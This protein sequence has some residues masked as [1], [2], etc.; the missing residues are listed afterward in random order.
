M[1]RLMSCGLVAAALS[2]LLSM[3]AAAATLA[4]QR[5][6]FGI[7][8]YDP[9]PVQETQTTPVPVPYAWIDDYPALLA[10]HSG[11]YEAAANASAANGRAV[12]TCYM[13][14]L[15]PLNNDATND[16][17]I[18]S[19]PMNADG[20]PDL[21]NILFYPPQTQW[22]VQGASP[23]LKGAASLDAKTWPTVTDENKSLFR[24]FKVEVELP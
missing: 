1:S 8:T 12:W 20:T 18:T 24:F 6:A 11:D 13:L 19:F 22:N 4:Q 21:A 16:F 10:G 2:L 3:N 5:G 14:G 7:V 15:D 9:V 23:V 17:R